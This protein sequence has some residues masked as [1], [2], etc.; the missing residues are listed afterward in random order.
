MSLRHYNNG[1]AEF[2]LEPVND[3]VVKV[4]RGDC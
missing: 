1:E 4:T 2:I 3:S